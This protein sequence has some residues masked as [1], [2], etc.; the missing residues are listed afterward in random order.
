MHPD[1][2]ITWT[3]P[4]GHWVL[5]RM[6]YSLTGSKNQ[7]A[8]AEATGFEVDKL[9]AAHVKAYFTSY[10][11]QY[12]NATGDLMGE[13]G[14]QYMVTDS[15]EAGV[16][17]W[18]DS[19]PIE[20][21]NHRGYKILPWLPV[22]TGRIVESAEAS[23]RFLWDFRKTIGDLIAENH[24]DELSALLY[25][26]GMRR[27][28]ESHE[29]GRAFVGDGMEVKR[30]A[31]IP[32][33]ALWVPG[34]FKGRNAPIPEVNKTMDIVES[35]SVAHLYGQNLVA[36]ESMTAGGAAWVW[37]PESLKPTADLELASG[38]NRFIIHCSVHQPVN[39]KIPGLGLGG[40][41]QWFTR[42]E[43]WA[44]Q[45]KPWITYLARSSYMLQKGKFVADIIYFYGEDN[46]IV[47]LFK[48]KLPDIPEGYNYDFVNADALVKLLSVSRGN[49]VTSGGMIY[50]ILAL[51]PNSKYMSF[52]VLHKI[53][54][55]VKDGAIV[56]GDKPVR[57]TQPQR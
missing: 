11:D 9:S 46:N 42:H 31:D 45:A 32:M 52:P 47:A 12:K 22:L 17:N 34:D 48:S 2:T 41:G 36:A 38:V 29:G 1:G 44:E 39:D 18:T 14:L 6:G 33:G 24:Y 27:Y 21:Q 53:G 7:P 49:I 8:S 54:E 13:K 50:R 26:R 10:L 30:K 15:W 16:Q 56:V 19:M 37:S 25:E 20:F 43:T 4:R 28:T 23:D 51:D 35:A 57:Y 40:F 5:L 55:L 3:P